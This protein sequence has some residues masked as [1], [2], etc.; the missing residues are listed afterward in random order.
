[1]HREKK[2]KIDPDKELL[3]RFG[4]LPGM[5]NDKLAGI[6]NVLKQTNTPNTILKQN[7]KAEDLADQVKFQNLQPKDTFMSPDDE[8][9][10][11]DYS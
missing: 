7:L 11:A 5:T 8:M 4:T 9:L 10:Q 1:M 6:K 3:K 2:Q